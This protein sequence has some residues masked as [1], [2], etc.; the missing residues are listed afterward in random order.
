MSFL[1]HSALASALL[2][3]IA[4]VA[5]THSGHGVQPAAAPA[6]GRVAEAGSTP[7]HNADAAGYRSAFGGFRR[8]S[9]Q[10]VMSWREANDVVGRIGGW[11]AYAREAQGAPAGPGAMP[12]SAPAAPTPKASPAPAAPASGARP[13]GHSGHE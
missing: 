2:A 5:Q 3:P 4:A 6:S 10:P 13:G 7:A 1:T 8:Y 11:Q 12:A 9:E